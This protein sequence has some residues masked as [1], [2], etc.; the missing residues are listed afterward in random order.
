MYLEIGTTHI[1]HIASDK[2]KLKKT[3]D[4]SDSLITNGEYM[5]PV[6]RKKCVFS[7]NPENWYGGDGYYYYTD[8]GDIKTF[9][10]KYGIN[11]VKMMNNEKG[12]RV[13]C[14]KCFFP[15]IGRTDYIV[16]LMGSQDGVGGQYGGF[17]FTVYNKTETSFYV[18]CTGT[19]P[20]T[21]QNTYANG[22][23][24]VQVLY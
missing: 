22:Y 14:F 12:V 3:L 17:I 8:D 16:N 10:V 21:F 1:I 11:N 24:D 20:V 9:S 7:N 18:S 2:I 23:I 13:G 4:I 15:S 5:V 6:I 19:P